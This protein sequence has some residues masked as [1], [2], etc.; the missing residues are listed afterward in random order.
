MSSD[1]DEWIGR[2]VQC[3][4]AKGQAIGA[5]VHRSE[6]Y[7]APFRVLMMDTVGPIQPQATKGYQ[8]VLT[9]IDMFSYWL[10]LLPLE[11]Q[12]AE[13]VA[14]MLYLHVMLDLAG[15]P[16]IL[17]SDNGKEF[18]GRIVR[19]LNRLLGTVQIFG[20]AYHPQSQ[21]LKEGEHRQLSEVLQ[22]FVDEAKEDWAD[23]L[24]IARWAW[25][26]SRKK[27]LAGMTPYQVVT[28]LLAR[29]PLANLLRLPARE[30]VTAEEYVQ[31]LMESAKAVWGLVVV[32]QERR[33][34]ASQ[35]RAES[36]RIRRH[37]VPGETVLLQ[38]PP[39][40]VTQ[41]E[42]GVSKRLVG[43][44]FPQVYRVLRRV[45]DTNYVIGDVLTG[46]EDGSIK[47][48][49]HAARLVPIACAELAA[50]IEQP[51]HVYVDGMRGKIQRVALDGRVLI[52]FG[53][54]ERNANW[55]FD[56]RHLGAV[57]EPA[58]RDGAHGIWVDLAVL[59]Y[60]WD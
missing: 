31:E 18:T 51:Q 47:Q 60:T 39:G 21:G 44:N 27:A 34:E 11:D 52:D 28:G 56:N 54:S 41:A 12:A 35:K 17:R 49:I 8:Y 33:A 53:S 29:S 30:Q 22:I 59:D 16:A 1:C 24:P 7:S 19:E 43:K 57:A 50:A 2:C 23:Q 46:K 5:S 58:S 3:R 20:S 55:A 37:L 45:G 25:N 40:K 10:W 4:I 38:R 14:K 15:F 36:G 13:E 32:A 6:R 26:T 42:A 48:P 9:V